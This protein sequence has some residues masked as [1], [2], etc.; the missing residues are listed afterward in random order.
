MTET[1]LGAVVPST[2]TTVEPEFTGAVPRDTTVHFARMPLAA[3][4]ADALSEMAETA[5]ERARTL[6]DVSPDAVAY[7]CTT[8]SLVRGPA[9][10]VD[11]EERLSDAVGAP[12][13]VTARSVVRALDAFGVDSVAVCTPYNEDLTG[14]EEE[15]LV[16]AGFDVVHAGGR[17]IE[18]NARI[19]ALTPLDAARQALAAP[20]E[21]ADAVFVSCTNYRTLPTVEWLEEAVGIPVVT[22]NL[23][24]LWDVAAAANQWPDFLPGALADAPH[25]GR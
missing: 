12:A 20:T 2:N 3:V 7:A 13:V 19:G 6:A 24:T 4:T 21:E 5:V 14:R 11:L 16:D 8:G 18:D 22:S 1:R 10:A 23:A 15:F 17:G 25:P 9:F